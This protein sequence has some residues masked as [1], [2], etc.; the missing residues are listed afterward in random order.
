MSTGVLNQIS[1]KKESAWGTAVVPDKSIPVDFS[2]GIK[3]D[4]DIKFNQELKAQ[5]AKNINSYIGAQKHEGEFTLDFMPDYPAYFILGAL[6]AVNSALKGGESTVYE[7]TI[8]EQESKPSFTIEQAIDQNVKRFAGCLV[9]NFKISG[10]AGESV[11]FV[12][13]VKGK[14]QATASK[15]TAAYTTPRPYNWKDVSIKLGGTA[16]GEVENFEIEYINGLE[17]LHALNATNDPAYNYVKASEVKGKVELYLDSTTAAFITDYLGKT[18]RSVELI[19]TGDVI[20]SASNN[21]FDMT[22]PKAVFTSAETPLRE[23]YNLLTIEFQGVYDTATS[24]LLNV[25]V[26]NLLTNLT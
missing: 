2:G 17:V 16:I 26:T 11:K 19:L 12:F 1:F 13:G 15:I 7:H 24:K 20:G 8:T 3:T 5:L 14:S 9:T 4:L 22:I 23:D 18:E 6:G 21:K 25:V 10:K